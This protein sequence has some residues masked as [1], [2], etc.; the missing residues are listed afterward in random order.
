MKTN[1]TT[2][3]M[4]RTK[5]LLGVLFSIVL[6]IL[7]AL[8]DYFGFIFSGYILNLVNPNNDSLFLTV[9]ISIVISAISL[10]VALDLEE[11]YKKDTSYK[12]DVLEISVGYSVL[13]LCSNIF[14]G[15]IALFYRRNK[16]DVFEIC[17]SYCS[18]VFLYN[19]FFGLLSLMNRGFIFHLF[20]D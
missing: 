6:L 12:K 13:L 8:H 2:V 14:W 4:V 11:K 20:L 9:V 7:S 16:E 15:V 3:N 19:S 17:A 1:N 18:L 10:I 5:I